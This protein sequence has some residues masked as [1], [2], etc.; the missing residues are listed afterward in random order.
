MVVE[1]VNIYHFSKFSDKNRRLYLK[2]VAIFPTRL[3]GKKPII[4]TFCAPTV[5]E[6][7]SKAAGTTFRRPRNGRKA[8]PKEQEVRRSGQ[9]AL[10]IPHKW[11]WKW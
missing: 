3:D 7:R 5:P 10:Q 2:N 6:N 9:P 11:W 1:V 8:H 4:A